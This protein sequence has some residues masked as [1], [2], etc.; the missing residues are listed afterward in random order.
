MPPASLGPGKCS[1]P[2][3]CRGVPARLCHGERDGSLGKLEKL[4]S[5]SFELMERLKVAP[6][7][8]VTGGNSGSALSALGSLFLTDGLFLTGLPV[9]FYVVQYISEFCSKCLNRHVMGF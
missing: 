5:L 6:F 8:I 4:P 2:P 7:N 9:T 1:L 3:S